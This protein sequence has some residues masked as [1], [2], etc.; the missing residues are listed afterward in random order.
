MK[1]KASVM[2]LGFICFPIVVLQTS[3]YFLFFSPSLSTQTLHVVSLDFLTTWWPQCIWISHM[4]AQ[5]SSRRPG[6]KLRVMSRARLGRVCF[7]LNLV[8]A[9]WGQPKFI[10]R[11]SRTYLLLGGGSKYFQW[12][13]LC[14]RVDYLYGNS[15]AYQ[16]KKKEG[17]L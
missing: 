11:G 4:T 3:P 16:A 12:S 9:G 10:G 13:L 1:G 6:W 2:P 8:R 7:P 5:D 14:H 15:I 17:V